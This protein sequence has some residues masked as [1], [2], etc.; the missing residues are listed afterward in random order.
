MSNRHKYK[1]LFN[2]KTKERLEV[3]LLILNLVLTIVLIG[4]SFRA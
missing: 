4:N 3:Y 1:R 2:R